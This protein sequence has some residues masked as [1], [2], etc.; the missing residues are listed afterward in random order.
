[1]SRNGPRLAATSREPED[2]AKATEAAREVRATVA[3]QLAELIISGDLMGGRG[4]L[5]LRLQR[6]LEAESRVGTAQR[7]R[8][9]ARQ[10]GL[11]EAPAVRAEQE[12]REAI[13]AAVMEVAVCAGQWVAAIDFEAAAE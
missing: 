3:A 1:M 2:W 13:R 11:P 12:G 5:T 10:A 4:A 7:A 6:L 9:H 8:V